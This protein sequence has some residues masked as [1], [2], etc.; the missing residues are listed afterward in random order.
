MNIISIK[1][2]ILGVLLLLSYSSAAQ[3]EI[4]AATVPP[5]TPISLIENIF[6][7]S[8][9]EVLDIQFDGQNPSVG[10]FNNA[11][12]ELGIERGIVMS[13]GRAASNQDPNGNLIA[14]WGAD[15]PATS[16]ANTGIGSTASDVDISQIA[17]S[18]APEDIAKFTITFIPVSDTLRFRYVFGSE[19]YPNFT[20]SNFNDIF[21]FFISGPGFSGPFENGGEN[22]ALIP[23][24]TLPVTINSL[25]GGVP[26]GGPASNCS[27]PNG[28]LNFSQF[29]VDNAGS[30]A[31]PVY[32]GYTTV[33]TAEAIVTPCQEY[34][35]KLVIADAGDNALDSGVFLE[36]K[37]FGTGSL[38]V[39][40]QIVS[41]DET[42]A[43]G[44]ASGEIV[45][46]VPNPPDTDFPL[47]I[48]II[49]TATNGVDYE[50]ILNNLVI[51]AGDSSVSL[52]IT[53][54][55]DGIDE[56][57][58]SII[59]DVRINP[60]LRDT[61]SIFIK[62]NELTAPSL[63]RDTT[64]CLGD[65]VSYN[66][67]SSTVIPPAMTFTNPNDLFINPDL[68]TFIS[69]IEVTDVF[70]RILGPGVIASIC[71]NLEH[72]WIDDMD[73]FLV[74][75]SGAFLELT[76]DNGAN[77]DDYV[78]TCFTVDA[79][80]LISA[81]GPV[82]PASAAP[83]TGDWLPEGKWS[84]LW[85]GPT[86]G[87]W[88]LLVRDDAMGFQGTLLDWTITFE[89]IYDIQYNWSPNQD[90]LCTDCPATVVYP[91]DTTTYILSVTDSYGCEILDST[92]VNPV[93]SLP[94][95]VINCDNI[96]G[97]SIEFNWADINGSLGYEVNIDGAGWMSPN[98]DQ[99]THEITGLGFEDTIT[100]DVRGMF[101]CGAQTATL[102]CATP[103]CDLSLVTV[104]SASCFGISDGSISVV[105]TGGLG[106]TAYIYQLGTQSNNS[107]VFTG[108]AAGT[109][110]VTV[111]DGLICD[112]SIMVEV[113]EPS[114]ILLG[115]QV[116]E[117]ISC[118]GLSD[119]VG[120]V[121]ANGGNAPYS[122]SWDGGM[123][124][125][126]IATGLAVGIH[127][128]I[129]TDGN[130]CQMSESI[131]ITEPFALSLTPDSTEVTCNG[132]SDGTATAIPIGGSSPYTYL[133][134]VNA[135]S[136]MSQTA[137][138]LSPGTFSV[139]ITDDSLCSIVTTI[140][141]LEPSEIVSSISGNDPLC[142]DGSDGTA[143]V[144]PSGGTAGYTFQWND[145]TN[146]MSDTVNNLS[147]QMYMVTVTDSRNCTTLDSITLN[148]PDEFIVG[149]TQI[150]VL[151]NAESTGSITANVTNLVGMPTYNW[152][153]GQMT[154]TINNLSAGEYCVTVRDG[155]NCPETYCTT[156]EEPSA[157]NVNENIIPAGCNGQMNG[158]IE[159]SLN[160]G[161]G[162]YQ[163]S[164]LTGQTD[165]TINNLS[166]GDYEAL[167]IDSN[168]CEITYIGTVTENAP[169][170]L[171]L[172]GNDI[173][174]FDENDGSIITQTSGTSSSLSYA[175][176]G[177]NGFISDSA[178][179]NN[180]AAGLYQVEITDTEGCSVM[181]TYTIEEPAAILSDFLVDDVRCFGESNGFV[182]V[183]TDFGTAP[184]VY[185]IDD[186]ENFQSTAIFNGLSEGVYPIITQD[187]N[188][189][190][191][192]DSIE[193]G[194]PDL[195]GITLDTFYEIKFGDN[196]QFQA[197]VNLAG[198]AIDSIFWITNDTTLSC[199]NCFNPVASP[200][201][202]TTY[203][204]TIVDTAGCIVTQE[205]RVVVNREPAIYVPSAF[206]PND[207]GVND[208]LNIYTGDRIVLEIESF[209]IF[210]RWG[211]QV[212]SV[213]EKLPSDVGPGWDGKL[214]GS[215]M[216]PGV[217]VWIAKIKF[218]DGKVEV[219]S[220]DITLLR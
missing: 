142:N 90:I 1:N 74:T 31:G 170:L 34:T 136:Q 88:Q 92:N 210:D 73:I 192:L 50:Q 140:E 115:P 187:A 182:V 53:P 11:E 109:Y 21:G 202:T 215:K 42:L 200:E 26:T 123:Q 75:P 155:N 179:I 57:L 163:I 139:T 125:D 211:E 23:G 165:S 180:L 89:Q 184:F 7:G 44:C 25:N 98:I 97:T 22:I 40:T 43:E 55:E 198:S 190:E 121:L 143:T 82:A 216:N 152:D 156:I 157:L 174:C 137:S 49:G 176:V 10:F 30:T 138:S 117:Q 51:P 67:L 32:D 175:W 84:D 153:S 99:L 3:L 150:D 94:E 102:T 196:V 219:Y 185:S 5:L 64:I 144:V 8:G 108:L 209:L 116:V 130:N 9:V 148:N 101:P 193:V 208:L 214:K 205:A 119:G 189:C 33:L 186:G 38:E 134:D 135:N 122:F 127:T 19:E 71:L 62:D 158:A 169:F 160:G 149:S 161:V 218:I 37:S 76:T 13:S 206:S 83:F 35:I 166:A 167:I 107:G 87:T 118:N 39:S 54:L 45:F 47:D 132:D 104:D 120:T 201:Y 213:F 81:P 110:E 66:G 96:T 61:F 212:Y 4:Q 191:K 60:C 171:A 14:P 220:G 63:A 145:P 207:D 124:T 133:W 78:N 86:N 204:L 159:L 162:P 2:C 151:C 28:S 91:P 172:N 199:E 56:P 105:A 79:T 77:G 111:I 168:L 12:A 197:I 173:T 93:D 59:L 106:A 58:E 126:S 195:L 27:P 48:N 178:N 95:P 6:L 203:N 80:T 72:V 70:P 177:P 85:G 194:Q 113:F 41:L 52:T 181:D 103:V 65:S 100:I 46:S 16:F 147:G 15:A 36:A 154:E 114:P 217:F 29:F 141:V 188:G 146:A 164:W 183:N 20:C 69:E 112:Q 131:T 68:M 128:V 17:G 129:V 18:N 24:T